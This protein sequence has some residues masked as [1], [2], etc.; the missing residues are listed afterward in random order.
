[1]ARNAEIKR[2][3]RETDIELSFEL[4]GSGTYDVSTGIGFFDHMLELFT[5][6]GM[7]DLKLKASGDLHVGGHH[8][9]EDVGICLGQAVKKAVADKGGIKRY[10]SM[11]LPMDESLALVAI[12]LS[13]RPYLAYNVDL[14]SEK[15]GGFDTDL[16]HEFLGAFVNNAEMT[17]HVRLMTGMNAH[18]MIE[19]IFKGLARALDEATSMDERS[20]AVPSTKGSL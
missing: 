20:D 9:V 16:T 15:V 4:D 7:F 10:G 5:R 1:M 18:H 2:K 13:G 17:L 11:V 6:H 14:S 12:D 8:V 19:A 3:T